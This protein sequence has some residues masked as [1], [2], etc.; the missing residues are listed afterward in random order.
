[1]QDL[2]TLDI[3]DRTNAK[4]V[5][6]VKGAFFAYIA[7]EYNLPDQHNVSYVCPDPS[8]GDVIGWKLEKNV[9]RAWCYN[10]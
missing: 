6:R 8:Q 5:S 4:E 2:V 3:T 1:M 7:P 10:P 9:K